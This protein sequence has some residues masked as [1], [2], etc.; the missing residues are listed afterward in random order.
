[1]DLSHR[2]YFSDY[3]LKKIQ[4]NNESEIMQVVLEEA[5]SSYANEIIVEL[6]SDST[7]DLENNVER[8][9]QWIQN[10]KADHG[11]TTASA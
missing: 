1:M 4:E 3:S 5:R 2:I 7:D 11:V 9:I 10:W 6:N 8:I